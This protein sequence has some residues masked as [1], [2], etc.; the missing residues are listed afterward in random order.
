MA[1]T[2]DYDMQEV[3]IPTVQEYVAY[4]R[5]KTTPEALM[6]KGLVRICSEVDS[7][8]TGELRQKINECKRRRMD[9][10]EFTKE[11]K[12]MTR[13]MD[14]IKW[15]LTDTPLPLSFERRVYRRRLDSP[16][17]FTRQ[18]RSSSTIHREGLVWRRRRGQQQQQPPVAAVT[19]PDQ[20]SSPSSDCAP[21]G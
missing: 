11:V 14:V 15:G 12:K 16:P 6:K 7:F 2:L 19:G 10:R 8:L 18:V 20:T 4:F 13:A 3:A 9:R 5:S 17:E 1:H 21:L